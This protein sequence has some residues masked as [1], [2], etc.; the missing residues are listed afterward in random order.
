[1]SSTYP[2]KATKNTRNLGPSY[3]GASNAAAIA[4][5]TVKVTYPSVDSDKLAAIE[6]KADVTD[7]TSVSLAGALM[8]G[9]GTMTGSIYGNNAWT[10]ENMSYMS[11]ATISTGTI[12]ERSPGDGVT[13]DGVLLKD[14][15][16]T[17]TSIQPVI[18]GDDLLVGGVT[19]TDDTVHARVIDTNDEIKT[20]TVPVV[21]TP[22][23]R[24]LG[25][26][27]G[28]V[29]NT[30]ATNPT[31]EWYPNNTIYPSLQISSTDSITSGI[32]FDCYLNSDTF[33]LP[34]L[35][36]SS[37]IGGYIMQAANGG[38]RISYVGGAPVG[39]ASVAPDPSFIL[40]P[41]GTI[42]TKA[43][44]PMDNKTWDLGAVNARWDS[45][46]LRNG[47]ALTSDATEKKNIVAC[48]LGIDFIKAL[49]PKQYQWIDG[50]TRV[51]Y[52]LIAQDVGV[53]L[54]DLKQDFGGYVAST[55]DIFEQETVTING[56]DELVDGAKIGEKNHF[57]L[58]YQ[59]FICPL[60]CAM[61]QLEA[62]LAACEATLA[63]L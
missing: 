1:M 9:G 52:G 8:L 23:G 62:R 5:N 26:K 2:N 59:E 61:K 58:R 49:Q 35:N 41:T 11:T 27:M 31:L 29:S 55:T 45:I 21:V 28:G 47:A 17:T 34:Q 53:V 15:I 7:A 37:P 54:D 6:A 16:V 48:D 63:A 3:L 20:G 18:P 42:Y 51:H 50:D 25:I 38:F 32:Y 44:L 13:V 36:S 46:W 57:A 14:N 19:V 22:A 43:I 12:V 10:V 56:V 4:L 24:P 33:G 40:N 39:T 30:T 60:I